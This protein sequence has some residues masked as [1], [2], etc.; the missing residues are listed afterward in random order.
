[1]S[2]SARM[3]TRDRDRTTWLV[4]GMGSMAYGKER[5]AATAFKHM[6]L[7]RPHFLTTVWEDGSVR[8]LLRANQFE[9]TPLTIGYLGRARL[10]WTLTNL[11]HMPK[12]YWNVLRIYCQTHSHGIVILGLV[13]FANVLVPL[14]LLKLF[15]RAKFVF[16]LGDIPA[17][18]WPNKVIG[19]IMNRT[20][21]ATI[22]NSESVRRGLEAVGTQPTRVEVLYNGLELER[23]NKP[24]SF[25]WREDFHWPQETLVVGYAGQFTPMKGVEDFVA[26]A[27]L[28][29]AR[30]DAC[31][32]V[33]IGKSDKTNSCY[34]ALVDRINQQGLQR[35][36]VFSGWVADIERA[37]ATLNVLVVPSRHEEAGA[38]VIIEALATSV[39][40]IAT[41][42]GGTPELLEDRATGFLVE[43][44]QPAQI[45]EKIELLAN[46]RSLL[47]QLSSAAQASARER[48]DAQKI[49]RKL[50][51]VLLGSV[52]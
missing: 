15:L 12:L 48:F 39:P 52:N 28:V 9:F 45:A 5:R 10:R 34:G 50:Q 1:M 44:Q 8:D 40:V 17:T 3:S 22:V 47:R 11:W 13:P 29:L 38:N 26:A 21:T 27:E 43:K 51:S 6:P 20:A 4:V 14:L 7:I 18:T 46:D 41:N 24:V 32:F 19:R 25:Q 36:I 23:F 49:G 16:Y 42:T 2:Q 31:R 30:T 35:K 33:L 37:Y